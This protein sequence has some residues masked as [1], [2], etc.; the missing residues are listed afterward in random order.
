ML[1][2]FSARAFSTEAFLT[3]YRRRDA[4][5][6]PVVVPDMPAH[7]LAF[8]LPAAYL[9]PMCAQLALLR[10]AAWEYSA[11]RLLIGGA[12]LMGR[13]GG[14]FNF[15]SLDTAARWAALQRDRAQAEVQGMA[16]LSAGQLSAWKLARAA[17]L[18]DYALQVLAKAE[19]QADPAKQAAMV[20]EVNFS[21]SKWSS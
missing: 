15:R 4:G 9:C 10:G 1:G 13:A 17:A 8:A 19:K 11:G 3:Q 2:A 6:G 18:A 16:R 12:V 5:S 14:D 7:W 21:Q 20:A